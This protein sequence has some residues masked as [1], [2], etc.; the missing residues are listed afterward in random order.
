MDDLIL[1]KIRITKKKFRNIKK[2]TT[3]GR[4]CEK[5]HHWYQII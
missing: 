2:I 5:K 4:K 1:N 3:L